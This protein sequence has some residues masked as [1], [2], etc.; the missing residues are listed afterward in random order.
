MLIVSWE[1][2]GSILPEFST[3]ALYDFRGS[4]PQEPPAKIWQR[5]FYDRIIR[6]D[7]SLQAVRSYIDNNPLVWWQKR[8]EC[9]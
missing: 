5:S 1:S 2:P 3:F 4:L 8:Q 6:N 7:E 9:E